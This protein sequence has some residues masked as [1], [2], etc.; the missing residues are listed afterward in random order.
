MRVKRFAVMRKMSLIF[1]GAVAGAALTLSV[2]HPAAV[3]VG[4]TAEAALSH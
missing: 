4:S 2:T 1:L 3:S